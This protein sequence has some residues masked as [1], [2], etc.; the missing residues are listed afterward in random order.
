MQRAALL[1]MTIVSVGCGGPDLLCTMSVEPAI[2]LFVYDATTAEPAWW[3]AAGV[4]RDGAFE[5]SLWA[6]SWLDSTVAIPMR[7]ADERP[8]TYSI[9]LERSG[10]VPWDTSGILVTAGV[11]HVQTV[12]VDAQL[13]RIPE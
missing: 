2:E 3:S 8:G 11:C 12:Q 7:A 13:S 6:P 10:Y 9:H 1:A 4:V 5:D